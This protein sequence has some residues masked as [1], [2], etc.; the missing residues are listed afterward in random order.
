MHVVSQAAVKDC[1]FQCAARHPGRLFLRQEGIFILLIGS[2]WRTELDWVQTEDAEV[3]SKR[4]S[5]I[6][7]VQVLWRPYGGAAVVLR[8]CVGTSIW[9]E[10]M[11]ALRQPE[12]LSY[13]I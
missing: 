9:T 12:C 13:D 1:A 4:P 7:S 10:I 3:Q 8:L 5:G 6:A 11:Q 2:T